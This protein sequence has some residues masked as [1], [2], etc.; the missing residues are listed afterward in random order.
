[1]TAGRYEKMFAAR[2]AEGRGA[3][4]PFV[5][6]GD[7]TPARSLEIVAALVA[8]GADA[9]ELGIPFSDPIA[10]GPTIQAAD[11][12]ALQAGVTPDHC[13]EI[14][15][16]VRAD[17]PAIPLGLLL[18]ANLPYSVGLE[19][20]YGRAAAAG[21]DAILVADVPVAESRPFV[22]AAESQSICPVLIAPPNAGTEQLHAIAAT[23]QGFTYVVAR[24]GVTGVTAADEPVQLAC[25][26]ILQRLHSLGAPPALIGFGI[27]RP[28]HVRAALEAGAAGAISGS[29]VVR[30]IEQ[31]LQHPERLAP[32]LTEFVREMKAAT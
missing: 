23:S 20:F 2:A 1:M 25:R 15:R 10:D 32:R 30:L 26:D 11:E 27:S 28:E 8:G 14:L 4:V 17:H 19:N 31:H 29:A 13:W 24:P 9:L 21:V 12:R 3:F 5:V 6:L 18:Y 16:Q 22:G 7:P